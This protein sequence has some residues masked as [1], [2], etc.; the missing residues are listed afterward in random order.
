MK[1]IGYL[2]AIVTVTI[3]SSTF[4]VT[5]IILEYMSP[6][7]LLTYRM[8]LATLAMFLI[9]PK[10]QKPTSI[11]EESWYMLSGLALAAYFIFENTAID[12]TFPSNVGL[13]VALS[14]IVTTM[15]LSIRTK[16]SYFNKPRTIG[17]VLALIGVGLVVFGESGFEGFS[18]IGDLLAIGAAVSFSFYTIFLKEMKQ[19]N[20]IIQRTRKV[21]LYMFIYI[22]F[23]ALFRGVDF[24]ILHQSTSVIL[25][26][27]FLAILASSFAFIFWNKALEVLGT[28]ETSVFIYLIPV[29]TMIFSKIV[30]DDPITLLK[31]FGTVCIIVG[32]IFSE[33]KVQADA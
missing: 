19:E 11:K 18:P 23:F 20:H 2:L 25:G 15:L 5:K 31:V 10:Y 28:F 3:W 29:I 32:L 33:K 17:L 6:V 1:P 9:Y 7:E 21:F 22:L 24:N 16:V 27:V 12:K 30:L 8:F 13:L 14:P 4:I 26:V